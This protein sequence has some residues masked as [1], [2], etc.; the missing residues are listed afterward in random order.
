MKNINTLFSVHC[1]SNLYQN[2]LFLKTKYYSNDLDL[3]DYYR[4]LKLPRFSPSC[5]A[6][7]CMLE[8]TAVVLFTKSIF[9]T[10]FEL[11]A[12]LCDRYVSLVLELR[13]YKNNSDQFERIP[14]LNLPHIFNHRM[15]HAW[16]N[17]H[18]F[19]EC[20]QKQT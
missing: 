2:G 1:Y 7:P 16:A 3:H 9:R 13:Q 8:Q 14:R 17:Q 20:K 5:F 15:S 10:I 6:R 19:S 12:A 11:Y 18:V 4:V